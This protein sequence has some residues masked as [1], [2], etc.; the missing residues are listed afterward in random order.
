MTN[1]TFMC[2]YTTALIASNYIGAERDL[3]HYLR[4]YNRAYPLLAGSRES[5]QLSNTTAS[6]Y[7]CSQQVNFLAALSRFVFGSVRKV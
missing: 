5:L 1:V 6:Y 2:A 7:A 3:I 4:G